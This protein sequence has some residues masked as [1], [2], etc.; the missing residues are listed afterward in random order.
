MFIKKLILNGFKSFCDY[1]EINF[2]KGISAIVGPNGCGKSNIIDA[3]MWVI[4]EQR[5]KALR[6]NSM[7]DVIFSGSETRKPLGRAEVRLILANE[8]NILPLD[9]D[10]VEIARVIYANGENE[11]YINREKVRLKDIQELFLDTGIGKAAY[12]VMAQGRID[13]ILSNKPEDRRYIIEEAAGITKYKLRKMEALSR[14]NQ[15]EE[16]IIRIKDILEEVKVQYEHVKKQA[17]KAERYKKLYDREIELEIELNLKRIATQKK[18]LEQL[19]SRKT[20][21]ENEIL[22]YKTHLEQLENEI[23]EKIQK[24][25]EY[26]TKKIEG[27]R[28]IFSIQSELK[29]L[30]SKTEMVKEQIKLIENSNKNDLEKIK[31]YEENLKD[32]DNELHNIERTKENIE[33]QIEQIKEDIEINLSNISRIE[34]NIIEFNKKI[35]ELK[36]NILK[37]NEELEKKKIDQKIKT[38]ELVVKID[39]SLTVFNENYKT[40]EQLKK[41]IFEKSNYILTI[42]P[43]RRAFIDDILKMGYLSKSSDEFI[44]M[45]KNF[46][47]EL[48]KIENNIK[49]I[50]NE[51]KEYTTKIDEILVDIFHPNGVLQQKRALE[52]EINEMLNKIAMNTERIEELRF[53]INKSR[54]NKEEFN[55]LIHELNINLTTA[56]EKKNSIIN[57]VKRLLDIRNHHEQSIIELKKNIDNNKIKISQFNMELETIEEKTE[58]LNEKRAEIE[59]ILIEMDN[60]I[61][62]ENERMVQFQNVIKETNNKLNEKKGELDEINIKITETTTTIKNIY[63]T[64]YENYSI[65]LETYERNDVKKERDQEEI[66]KELSEVKKEKA[67]LGSVNLIAIEEAKSLEERLNLL[68]TQLADLDLAKKDI[69]EL[70]ETINRESKELFL[71]T[72]KEIR[73]NFH[74]IFQKLFD[75]GSAD[76][77]LIDPENVLESGIEIIAHPPG[78]KTQSISLLSGGQRTLIAIA[79]MFAA[80]LVKPSPFCLLDEIDAALDEE[81]INR[82]INLLKE[83]KDKSQFIII[84]HN[85]KTIAA[86]D[87]MYGVTQEEKGVSKIVSAKISKKV[88][89]EV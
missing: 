39:Q 4:G 12:S 49:E 85:S 34:E 26:E 45:L 71:K 36:N 74:K 9:Y 57:D 13:M 41:S 66:K 43:T 68:K 32:I 1:S 82:F 65:N 76:I 83:F 70:L 2:V 86:A 52:T 22:E 28:E 11:Y 64:F 47:D 38:E 87:V 21:I 20:K 16:N 80:F 27:Q 67:E 46:G 55:K 30:T 59:K 75:G 58:E 62:E 44:S 56:N 19:F 25:A 10:E 14:L 84:T 31:I 15:A 35:E 77:Q 7:V 6:A 3:I 5:I 69:L 78:Q 73:I 72:F 54:D 79:I 23:H 37:I 88:G 61:K 29:I 81:N 60:K 42:F 33:D 8:Q 89:Q 63:D 18:L 50:N 53:E 48:N 24:L 17:E 40:I 51:I